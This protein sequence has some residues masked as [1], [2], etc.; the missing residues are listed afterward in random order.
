MRRQ[1]I[2][3]LLHDRAQFI[4]S[5]A[6][7]DDFTKEHDAILCA[8]SDEICAGLRIIVSG[9]RREWRRGRGALVIDAGR[10]VETRRYRPPDLCTAWRNCFLWTPVCLAGAQSHFTV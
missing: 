2:P 9:K 6:A 10:G 5:Q 8:G 7:V 3:R 4:Q 1:I